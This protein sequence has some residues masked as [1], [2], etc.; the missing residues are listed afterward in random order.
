MPLRLNPPGYRRN[1]DISIDVFYT[2]R[3]V[4]NRVEEKP[5]AAISQVL[6]MQRSRVRVATWSAVPL[7]FVPLTALFSLRAPTQSMRIQ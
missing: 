1:R 5:L 6:T 3:C 7:L 2:S 4:R